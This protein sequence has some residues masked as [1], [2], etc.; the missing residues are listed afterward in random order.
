MSRAVVVTAL[1]GPEVL[2]FEDWPVGEPGPGEIRIRQRAVGVNFVD[3][4]Q[5]RGTY[6][7]K[8]PFVAGNEGAG[9]VVALGEGVTEV[10]VGDRIAY[11]GTIG[12]YAEERLLPAAK[13]V[14]IPDDV[15]FEA[16]AAA[17]LKGL[18]AY[19]LLHR[20]FPVR[21]GQTI[22]W[23]AAAG[24]VGLLACQWAKALGARVIGAAGS[25]EKVALALANG[26][27]AVINYRSEAFAP[28]VRELTGGEGVDVVC[29]GNGQ[30]TFEA[31]LDCL[32]PLGMMVS[33]GAASGTVSIPD[34]GILMRKGSLFL[35]RPTGGHYYA[36]RE[37]L[38]TG[39]AALFAAVAD[40]TLK[41]HIGHRFA[42]RDAAEA[43]GA[44]EARQTI[45]S[46]VLIP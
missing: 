34:L 46:T 21:P 16:A 41:V 43:H 22:L 12:A 26:C 38:L 27:D 7:G 33:F 20:T 28:R 31:S 18:T 17:T 11:Q 3:I 24:G 42:L 9:E 13:A 1:G 2:S 5:R 23:H 36:Q 15:S 19:F 35:T 10:A 8:P 4:Y 37:D 45:G 39:A 44:L 14:R 30:E 6:P 29:D 25:D 40:G 32:R